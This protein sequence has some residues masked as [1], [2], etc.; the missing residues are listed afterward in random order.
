MSFPVPYST[1]L[2]A[3]VKMEEALAAGL[4]DMQASFPVSGGPGGIAFS[5]AAVLGPDDF[6]HAG[7]N[8]GGTYYSASLLKVAIP[9][10]AHQLRSAVEDAGNAAGATDGPST[11]AAA[12]LVIDPLV[13]NAVPTIVAAGVPHALR[14]PRYEDVF[15][16]VP[17]IDGHVAVMLNAA[18]ENSM[19]DALV[20]SSNSAA[21]TCIKSLG[22][23]WVNGALAAG[24][25]FSALGQQGI[26]LCGTFDGVTQAVRIASVNDGQAA[27]VMTTFDMA[28]MYAH[29]L[30]G[31]LVNASASSDF[32]QLL[33]DTAAGS[34]PS[35]MDASR[36]VGSTDFTV[37]HTEDRARPAQDRGQRLLRG[38]RDRPDRHVDPVHRGLAERPRRR[39]P[40]D[41]LPDRAGRAALPR[42]PVVS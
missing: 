1:L 41:V 3:D 30:R 37:T 39:P 10:C 13:A 6:P 12:R 28:N 8:F 9:Y 35:W 7:L 22:Y 17:T 4:A 32:D 36:P 23:G 14:V 21:A 42:E 11:Y 19:R 25:F 40:V 26:W 31:S 18:F 34:E 20:L 33:R 24:G 5:M 2:N 27:Q 16:T 15:A 29:V 38:Q